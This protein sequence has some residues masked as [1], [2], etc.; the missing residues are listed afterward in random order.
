MKKLSLSIITLL[1]LFVC[2][3]FATST[4]NEVVVESSV[5]AYSDFCDGWDDGYQAAC[6]G[7]MRNCMTPM[8]PIAP[9]GKDSYKHGYGMGY[10]K[11]QAKHCE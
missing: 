8:C 4:S 1:L 5:S 7:C 10:A 11:A 6:D 3:G 2:V 9:I